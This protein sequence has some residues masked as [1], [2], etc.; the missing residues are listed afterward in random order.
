MVAG[1]H[2]WSAA[3]NSEKDFAFI[4][5]RSSEDRSTTLPFFSFRRLVFCICIATIS[6]IYW[7]SFGGKRGY[8]SIGYYGYYGYYGHLAISRRLVIYIYV[9]GRLSLDQ[10]VLLSW[11]SNPSAH[12]TVAFVDQTLRLDVDVDVDGWYHDSDPLCY[13]HPMHTL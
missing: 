2:I 9:C 1:L 5:F 8:V 6:H 10:L 12:C 11:W 13:I 7:N 3:R 4:H